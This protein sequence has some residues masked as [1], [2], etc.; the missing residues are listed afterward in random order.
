MSNNKQDTFRQI[1]IR[2][3]VG[4]CPN[5]SLP[6]YDDGNYWQVLVTLEPINLP[7]NIKHDGFKKPQPSNQG[8][9]QL[10]VQ[11]NYNVKNSFVV[12]VKDRPEL[13][14]MGD[15]LKGRLVFIQGKPEIDEAIPHLI[16]VKDS[17][18][19]FLLLDQPTNQNKGE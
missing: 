19:I 9:A 7:K 5:Q 4:G 11:D 1:T 10:K 18:D 14:A 6:L 13:P 16:V 3:F 15:D 2:G 12:R 17:D 8:Q